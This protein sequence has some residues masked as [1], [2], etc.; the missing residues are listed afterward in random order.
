MKL[1][2]KNGGKA[3]TR[4]TCT[5]KCQVSTNLFTVLSVSLIYTENLFPNVPQK[6]K[7]YNFSCKAFST[8]IQHCT[9]YLPV[10]P[11]YQHVFKLY[12]IG[13]LCSLYI[14]FYMC[15]GYTTAFKNVKQCKISITVMLISED[16]H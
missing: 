15:R 7:I 14:Y 5:R 13:A 12:G 4:G 8:S 9:V 16:L 11:L 10:Y 3:C 1:S 2:L 6:L